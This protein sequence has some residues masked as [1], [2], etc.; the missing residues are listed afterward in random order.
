MSSPHCHLKANSQ[1]N[2]NC[3][4]KRKGQESPVF[5]H[6][7]SSVTLD[8]GSGLRTVSVLILPSGYEANREQTAGNMGP[9]LPM[10]PHDK[11]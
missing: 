7:F 4:P 6:A 3:S 8:S 10:V 2:P 11:V 9:V 5:K 1:L